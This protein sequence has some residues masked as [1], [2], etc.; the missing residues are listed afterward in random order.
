V[1][2]TWSNL[3]TNLADGNAGHTAGHNTTNSAANALAAY[4]DTLPED[5]DIATAVAAKQPLDADLTTIAAL[6]ST[7]A[8]ALATDGSGWVRKTYAQLKTAL[9]L[10]KAD[11]GL[12]NVDNTADTAKPISTAQQT[13]LD[14]K[15]PLASPAFTGTPTG[16]TKTHVGLGNV[17]N[18]ADTAKPD[19]VRPPRRRST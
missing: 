3:P 6:D 19:V 7:T 8:G 15:A 1:P 16:I 17:D 4:V 11:V 10:A 13:A 14:L 12:G 5:G 18:T 9:G 2:L